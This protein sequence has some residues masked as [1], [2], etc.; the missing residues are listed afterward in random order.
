MYE[1][2]LRELGL[3]DLE[4]RR[5]RT[6]LDA[7]FYFITRVMEKPDPNSSQQCTEVKGQEAT[8]TSCSKGNWDCIWEQILHHGRYK[9]PGQ[10]LA[11]LGKCGELSWAWTPATCSYC[12]VSPG[13]RQR[14]DEVTSR[15]PFQ[16]NFSMISMV[17][18]TYRMSEQFI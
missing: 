2:R 17:L 7:V 6:V 8:V 9:A 18:F 13:L 5:Q 1:E 14:L 15:S 4:K 16:A 11:R 3:V 10:P 12:R